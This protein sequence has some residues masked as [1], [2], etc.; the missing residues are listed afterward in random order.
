MQYCI[1]FKTDTHSKWRPAPALRS[2]TVHILWHLP[3]TA[4]A[5]GHMQWIKGMRFK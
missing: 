2:C 3:S 4:P 1:S 5:A